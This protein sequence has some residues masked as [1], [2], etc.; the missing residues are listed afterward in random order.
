MKAW[1]LALV[2]PVILAG[3]GGPDIETWRRNGSD[4]GLEFAAQ[5]WSATEVLNSCHRLIEGMTEKFGL[6]KSEQEAYMDGCAEA[7]MVGEAMLT[8][9]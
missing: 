8:G 9:E 7:A 3:C 1:S 2:L 5:G 6:A 4:D